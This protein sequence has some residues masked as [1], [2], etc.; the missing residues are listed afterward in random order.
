MAPSDVFNYTLNIDRRDLVIDWE[1]RGRYGGGAPP[2]QFVKQEASVEAKGSF[3]VNMDSGQVIPVQSEPSPTDLLPQFAAMSSAAYKSCNKWCEEPWVVDDLVATLVLSI[4]GNSQTLR[5][6]TWERSTGNK[7]LD[8]VLAGGQRLFANLSSDGR[9]LFIRDKAGEM[10]PTWPWYVFSVANGTQFAQ[11]T[12]EP[13]AQWVSVLDSRLYYVQESS[14]K[15]PVH[16]RS[17]V[18]RVLKARNFP[19]GNLI[20][21]LPLEGPLTSKAPPLRQ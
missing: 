12:Y 2:P 17:S 19:A 5:L 20:W 16:D 14:T 18:P 10:Q 13:G 6:Q 15:D 11:V 1:A 7:H 4:S 21:D 8:Q 3:R 9:F